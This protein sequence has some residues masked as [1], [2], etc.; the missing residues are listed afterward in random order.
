MK[1]ESIFSKIHTSNLI[2]EHRHI[3]VALSVDLAYYIADRRLQ[4]TVAVVTSSP[5]A[6]MS[7]VRK[8]WLRLMRLAQRERASTLSRRCK[9]RLDETLRDMQ[10]ISFTAKDPTG[11]LSA[12]VSFATVERF[13]TA[14]PMCATLYIVEPVTK[15]QLYM[16]AS[17]MRPGGLVVIYDR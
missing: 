7:S 1:S 9:D 5:Q 11:D 6:L 14:P 12:Y 8:Q 17:W 16:L 3:S 15:S 10:T 13:I 2:V 4:G